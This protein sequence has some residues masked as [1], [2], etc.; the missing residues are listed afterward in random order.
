MSTVDKTLAERGSWY[1]EFADNARV[2]QELYTRFCFYLGHNR[3]FTFS[4]VHTEALKFIAQKIARILNGDPNYKDN[5]HDI[6][7]YATLVERWIATQE[8]PEL[9]KL[10]TRD[11]SFPGVPTGVVLRE[12]PLDGGTSGTG[13]L[14]DRGVPVKPVE[15]TNLREGSTVRIPGV[16]EL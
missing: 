7:G 2:S 1:G 8:L 13:V 12:N 16:G 4:E 5:W 3:S 9:R 10:N 11:G 15:Y 14:G 6:A